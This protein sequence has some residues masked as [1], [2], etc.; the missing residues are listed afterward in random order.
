MWLS[1]SALTAVL[2]GLSVADTCAGHVLVEG[3][4]RAGAA[5]ISGD[6]GDGRNQPA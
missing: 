3:Y 5:W 6:F 4:G 2:L 1:G